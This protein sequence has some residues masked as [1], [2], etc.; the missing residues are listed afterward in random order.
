M[1]LISIQL[2]GEF[3][4]LKRKSYSY[5]FS[6]LVSKFLR[7]LKTWSEYST[8]DYTCYSQSLSWRINISWMWQPKKNHTDFKF[9]CTLKIKLQWNATQFFEMWIKFWD[10]VKQLVLSLHSFRPQQIITTSHVSIIDCHSI[11]HRL[12]SDK[13]VNAHNG[14]LNTFISRCFSSFHWHSL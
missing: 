4:L 5:W 12:L 1:L 2:A 11:F 13:S 3:K 9:W 7:F 14:N 6:A 8:R 10:C